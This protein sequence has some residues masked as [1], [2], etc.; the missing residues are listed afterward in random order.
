[1]IQQFR[2]ENVDS[3]VSDESAYNKVVNGKY[4]IATT[5][6]SII[7]FVQR[8]SIAKYL[9]EKKTTRNYTIWTHGD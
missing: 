7:I 4:S 3:S 8:Y 5:F 2:I 6:D 9:Y 1:M